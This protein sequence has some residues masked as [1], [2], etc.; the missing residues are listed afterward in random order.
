MK[1]LNLIAAAAIAL[2]ISSCFGIGP[3]IPSYNKVTDNVLNKDFLVYLPEGY[4]AS[5]KDWPLVL[6]LHGVRERGS[7][8]NKVKRHGPPMLI[9][10]KDRKFPFILLVPQCPK[11]DLWYEASQ[12]ERLK[13]LLDKIE[14]NYRIDL[15]R[16]YITGNSMGGGG[17]WRM[18]EDYPER[19]AAAI[20]ICSIGNPK[21]APV[22]KDLP[23]WTF[24]GKHDPYIP[25][26]VT[27]RMV[28]AL[29]AAGNK[30]VI[31]TLYEEKGHIVWTDAYNKPELFTW[32]LKHKRPK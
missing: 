8:L 15:D 19:F 31:F 6:Y 30:Q 29:K 1:K 21:K 11:N 9:E 24:H 27:E 23:I 13:D 12:L 7:N 28:K 2:F 5:D 22:L 17:T 26:I 20:P 10:K 25:Y 14:K 18:I 4:E 32:L 16:V 3:Y